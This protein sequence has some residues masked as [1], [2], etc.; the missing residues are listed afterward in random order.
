MT[1]R[2]LLWIIPAV[3]LVAAAGYTA[4]LVW[5]VQGELR[6]AETSASE[7]RSAW[8]SQ[9]DAA[10]DAAAD[11]LADEAAAAR[12][13][14]DG[15]WWG[16][17]EH[18]PL[19]GDDVSA[20]AAMSR[21]LD[22]IATDAVTPLGETVD[23]L[24]TLVADGRIDLDTVESLEDPV[25]R[26]HE[27]LVVADDDLAGLDSDG[28]V[29]ALRTRF[30]RY[31]DLVHDLRAGLASADTAV[32]VLP[33]MA[34]ADGVRSYLLI[35]QNNAEIR[36]SGGMPG[37]W[38]LLR[39][40]DGRIEMTRQGTAA[41]FP[42]AAR[43]VAPLSREEVAVYGEELGLYF[44]DPGWTMDFP[45]SAELWQAHWDRQFPETAIDGVVAIDPVAL[46]Y[47]LD[48][49]GPVTV[50]DVTLTSDNAVEELLNTPY[51]D[52][53][54]AAQDV[55]FAAASRSIF[56]AATGSLASPTA[57]VEGL[58]RAADE[59]RLLVAAFD[60]AVSEE[61]AGTRV[62]G[63]MAGDDGATP[64]VDIGLNDLTGS[65][66]SYY[67][68]YSAD[69][70]AM[71]CQSGRQDLAGTLTL[72]QVITPRDAAELPDSVTGGGRLGT[73]PGSQYVM[74]RVY[75]PYGGTLDQFRLDGR[76]LG[77]LE[78][79]ELDGRPVA[80]VDV[81]LSSRKDAVLTWQGTTGAGQTGPGEL[82]L[83]PSVVPGAKRSTFA[84]AC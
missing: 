62:E 54:P 37:S 33:T 65:K 25:G 40:D 34:G 9:D 72:S 75:G 4:W 27:A 35:F 81:L 82:A 64:H 71:R 15:L 51:L 12:D 3:L 66:M 21:S 70:A 58:N 61:I 16:A 36:A 44:Q 30:D 49:T 38:A 22:V 55:F 6:A 63:A 77:D 23:R 50:G 29:G 59:G 17:L 47:L 20:V 31:A 32:G 79:V 48:G 24:G 78:T 42:T 69:V 43:P 68:R 52:A 11:D 7:L 1:T 13:H 14:T 19:V 84:S 8:R 76:A 60:D 67:L 18:L 26:A 80:S 41:D 39:A 28:Y 57:F 5:Q 74:V 2:R 45:R 56:D 10:R 53:D 83:T 73:E 46:S